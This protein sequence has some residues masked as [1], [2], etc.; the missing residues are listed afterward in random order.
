MVPRERL[1]RLVD[2]IPDEKVREAEQ[3]LEMVA[4]SV[5]VELEDFLREREARIAEAYAKGY[6]E[7]PQDEWIGRAGLELGGRLLKDEPPL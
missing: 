5:V 3:V 4:T 1:H 2:G 7:H 6:G